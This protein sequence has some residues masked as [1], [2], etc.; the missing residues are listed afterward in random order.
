ML[1]MYVFV[2]IIE[3]VVC[4]VDFLATVSAQAKQIT[5]SLNYL[6][7]IFLS[8]MQC[9]TWID[10]AN[11]RNLWKTTVAAYLGSKKKRDNIS[12]FL[13]L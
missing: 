9:S 4:I 13:V 1:K 8:W 5:Q 11:N 3:V 12:L 6:K 7:N 10:V 2:I